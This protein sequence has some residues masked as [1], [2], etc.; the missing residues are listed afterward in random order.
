MPLG[1]TL[2]IPGAAAATEDAKDRHQQQQPLEVTHPSAHTTFRQRL[3]KGDQISS[4]SGV[5]QRTGAAPTKPAPAC[6]H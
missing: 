6:P 4:G 3:M 1:E 2:Q 5:G